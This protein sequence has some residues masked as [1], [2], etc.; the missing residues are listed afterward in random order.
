MDDGNDDKREGGRGSGGGNREAAT[1]QQRA[2]GCSAAVVLGPGE[3]RPVDGREG[4]AVIGIFTWL[5]GEEG[6]LL[7]PRGG[8]R[9]AH[10]LAEVHAPVVRLH[11]G[12]GEPATG[13][14]RLR[15]QRPVV[16][17]APLHLGTPGTLVPTAE[18]HLLA[19]FYCLALRID[20]DVDVG[21]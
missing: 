16:G 3:G 1:W 4:G 15:G 2:W 6:S 7:S 5:H 8:V 20:P 9:H 21:I 17:T 11:V 12:H 13:V 18:H 14:R 10:R 19:L